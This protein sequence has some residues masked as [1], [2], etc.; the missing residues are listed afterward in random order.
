MVFP[1]ILK[2]NVAVIW[3]ILKCYYVVDLILDSIWIILIFY[4]KFCAF[5]IILFYTVYFYLFYL[6]ITKFTK[7]DLELFISTG[8]QF[9]SKVME[10][11]H[12]GK[13]MFVKKNYWA[14]L[15]KMYHFR[16]WDIFFSL[17]GYPI[18]SIFQSQYIF[19]RCFCWSIFLPNYQNGY[20]HQTFQG[21]DMRRGALS[22]KYTWH[23]NRVVFLGQVTNNIHIFTSRRCID[24]TIGKVLT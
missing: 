4:C 7:W 18:N 23:L 11:S 12:K 22:H 16:I 13:N 21:G 3:T 5:K 15:L 20:C 2:E 17:S 6:R 1:N 9:Q 24:T 19:I 8:F 14:L 10:G